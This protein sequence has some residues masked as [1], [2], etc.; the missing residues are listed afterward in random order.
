MPALD[1]LFRVVND[2]NIS[3]IKVNENI[4]LLDSL[5]LSMGTH[6]DNPI[7]ISILNKILSR[8]PQRVKNDILTSG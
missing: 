7:L 8:M 3:G 4:R 2:K 6:R 1:K 5:P